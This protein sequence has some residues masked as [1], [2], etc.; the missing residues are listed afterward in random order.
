MVKD[1]LQGAFDDDLSDNELD[2]API[3]HTSSSPVQ[4]VVSTLLLLQSNRMLKLSPPV[5]LC[6]NLCQRCLCAEA[7]QS[8]TEFEP[9]EQSQT[10]QPDPDVAIP[11]IVSQIMQN[12]SPST[13]PRTQPKVAAPV[14]SFLPP[15]VI[16]ESEV[17]SPTRNQ[18]DLF[19]TGLE[20][21]ARSHVR[22]PLIPEVTNEQLR[23][24]IN[25]M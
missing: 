4:P 24:A 13:S 16:E 23:T 1:I 6:K 18:L 10:A 12:I 3:D 22:P 21:H 8:M 14:T 9:V 15:P 11:E 2:E 17:S 20:S 25:N 5:Q 7:I 19:D